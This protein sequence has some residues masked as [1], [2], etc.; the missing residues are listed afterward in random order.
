MTSIACDATGDLQILTRYRTWDVEQWS[1]IATPHTVGADEIGAVI[2]R[3]F[4]DPANRFAG[5]TVEWTEPF[6]IIRESG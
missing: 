2:V 4:N 3:N 5:C 6:E 1:P